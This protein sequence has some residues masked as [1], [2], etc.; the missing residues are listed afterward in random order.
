MNGRGNNTGVLSRQELF[1]LYLKVQSEPLHLRHI[2]SE[3]LYH[4]GQYAKVRVIFL[5]PYITRLIM[6]MG[7]VDA[8]RGV[9]KIIIPSP[10]A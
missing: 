8:I 4:Q 9:E 1:Y 7:L 3:Y 10:S 5:G 2:L 6:G